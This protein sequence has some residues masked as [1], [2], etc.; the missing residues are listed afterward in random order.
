MVGL[1]PPTIPGDLNGDGVVNC[2]DILIIRNSWGKRSTQQG[3]DPLADYNRDGVVNVFDLAA[4][5]KYLARG[6]KCK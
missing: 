5:S 2:Q 1:Y 3:F 4:V 6:A